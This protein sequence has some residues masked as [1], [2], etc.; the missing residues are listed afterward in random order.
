MERSCSVAVQVSDGG[1]TLVTTAIES[2]VLFSHRSN[3]YSSSE[4]RRQGYS[5]QKSHSEIDI[6]IVQ[7]N[8]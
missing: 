4:G 8:L 3:I 1:A 5:L 6:Q 7:C 2:D